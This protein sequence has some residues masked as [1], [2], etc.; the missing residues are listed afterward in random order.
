VYFTPADVGRLK[1][2]PTS[3]ELTPALVGTG[4]SRPGAAVPPATGDGPADAAQQVPEVEVMGTA[5]SYDDEIAPVMAR[6]AELEPFLL[7]AT[8]TPAPDVL[9]AVSQTLTGVQESLRG[10]EAPAAA[11]SAHALLLSA[12]DRARQSVAA[13]FSGDRAAQARQAIALWNLAAQ[14]K[15]S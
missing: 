1:P 10:I 3:A 11:A 6:L 4:F 12:L 5:T 7:S 15:E 9:G 14:K 2:A 13:D 8:R